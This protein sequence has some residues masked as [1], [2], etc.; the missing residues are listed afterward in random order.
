MDWVATFLAAA[1]AGADPRQP[2]D[3][4]SLLPVLENPDAIIER[5]LFW[6]MTFRAQKAMR[7]GPWKYLSIDGHH[8]LF[9]LSRDER[10]RAN[11]A[12]REP[13][14]LAELRAC[15]ETWERSMPP[16]PEDATYSLVY[17]PEDLPQ[18]S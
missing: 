14:R 7:R 17:G 10:E 2:L 18:P 6:R 5:E 1:G 8:Y 12:R 3:G 13:A 9:D 4:I 11:L 15:Y 16:I